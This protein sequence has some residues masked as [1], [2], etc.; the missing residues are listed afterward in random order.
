VYSKAFYV[1]FHYCAVVVLS[2][3]KEVPVIS[4]SSDRE[5]SEAFTFKL[6][7]YHFRISEIKVLL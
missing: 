5:P 2:F 4:E 7:T 1:G 3:G 6:L